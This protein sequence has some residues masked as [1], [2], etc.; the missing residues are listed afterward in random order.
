MNPEQKANMEIHRRQ[1]SGGRNK[2]LRHLVSKV[3]KKSISSSEDGY[4]RC[5]TKTVLLKNDDIAAGQFSE[6]TGPPKPFERQGGVIALS[7]PDDSSKKIGD[8]SNLITFLDNSFGCIAT[9]AYTFDTGDQVTFTA[10]CSQ[11]PFFTIT[12]GQGE[13]KGAEGFVQFMIEDPEG[14][15]HDITICSF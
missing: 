10:S 5:S 7:D 9:G 12:G 1:W 8:Y 14:F 15:T 6:L 13:F 3:G 4:H 2:K 11:L